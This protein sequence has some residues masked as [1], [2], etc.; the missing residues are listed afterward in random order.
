MGN[1]V[2]RSS[3]KRDLRLPGRPLEHQRPRALQEPRRRARRRRER[4]ADCLEERAQEGLRLARTRRPDRGRAADV[5]LHGRLA[6]GDAERRRLEH[7][8]RPDSSRPQPRREQ[9]DHAAVGVPDEV[10]GRIE[11]GGDES[12]VVVEVDRLRLGVRREARA[13]EDDQLEPLRQRREDGAPRGAPVRHAAVHE[14]DARSRAQHLDVHETTLQTLPLWPKYSGISAVTSSGMLAAD[15]PEQTPRPTFPPGAAG[16]VLLG[17][18]AGVIGLGALIGWAAGSVAYGFLVGA[19]VGIPAR[20][21]SPSTAAT[22]SAVSEASMF[23]TPRP[24]PGRVRAGAGRRGRRRARAA[25]L[26]RS[27]AGR[28]EAGRSAPCSGPP[29]R[30]SACCWRASRSAPITSPPQAWWGSG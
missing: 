19:I 17:T 9:R 3:A 7:G 8:Q 23:A 4:R 18:L 1:G 25:G 21:S 16:G 14:H 24:I 15:G 5:L 12:C 2:P 28:C 11:E 20:A 26:P 6:P 10:G 27:P 30:P 29:P 13:V 22:G